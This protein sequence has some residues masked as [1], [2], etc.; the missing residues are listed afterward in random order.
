MSQPFEIKKI[1]LTKKFNKSG[2]YAMKLFVN[3]HPQVVVVDDYIPYDTVCKWPVFA[4]KKTKN[5][6]PIL[7]E[8]AWAKINGTFEDIVTGSAWE[9]LKTLLPYP[10]IKMNLDGKEADEKKVCFEIKNALH[11][12]YMLTASSNSTEDGKD[13]SDQN[14]IILNH[15]YTITDFYEI[16]IGRKTEKLLKIANPWNK[17]DYKGKWFD[18]DSRWTNDLKKEV[19][20]EQKLSGEFYMNISD[21]MAGFNSL[22]ICKWDSFFDLASLKLTHKKNSYNLV[23]IVLPTKSYFSVGIHQPMERFF[24]KTDYKPAAMRLVVAKETNDPNRPYKHLFGTYRWS[25]DNLFEESPQFLE[26]GTYYAWV[27]LD[28]SNSIFNE[29]TLNIIGY[30]VKA[31]EIKH[32]E[33]PKFMK[34]V[35]KDYAR[36]KTK[37]TRINEDD[38]DIH[39]KYY[40]GEETGGYGF[41][42]YSNQSKLKTSVVEKIKFVKRTGIRLLYTKNQSDYSFFEVRAG[43]EKLLIFK[44]VGNGWSTS[45]NYQTYLKYT[46]NQLIRLC[47]KNGK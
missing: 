29:Y 13:D 25:R 1:F 4:G 46:P 6:W 17:Q 2:C 31:K 12:Q 5:I 33:C 26:K 20:F 8:K 45:Y 35:I 11:Y 39:C 42:Y 38:P 14:G 28:W 18:G 22:T 40:L 30:E 47:L 9:G 16:H 34:Y 19:K 23:K 21:F 32:E 3:G 7:L 41:Y 37:E 27:E 24:S 15:W 44:R 43:K 10:I 36:Y